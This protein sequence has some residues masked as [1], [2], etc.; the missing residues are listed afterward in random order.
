MGVKYKSRNNNMVQVAYFDN[1]GRARIRN[2]FKNR[3]KHFYSYAY[4]VETRT[5]TK[6]QAAFSW[7][8]SLGA[9]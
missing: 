3:H 5:G 8:G 7:K 4:F 1:I 9:Y 6:T 2:K